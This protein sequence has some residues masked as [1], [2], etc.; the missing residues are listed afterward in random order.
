M[1]LSGRAGKAEASGGSPNTK[2]PRAER[3]LAKNRVV[4]HVCTVPT[5]RKFEIESR[6]KE[7]GGDVLFESCHKKGEGRNDKLFREFEKML[8]TRACKR[9]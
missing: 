1:V 7:I 4:S 5:R 3:P 9:T 8:P 2:R 6:V